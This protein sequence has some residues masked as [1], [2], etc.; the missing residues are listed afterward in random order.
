M[1]QFQPF[2]YTPRYVQGSNPAKFFQQQLANVE[3]QIAKNTAE[4]IDQ[5]IGNQVLS[6]HI[7][8]S[9]YAA[10]ILQDP[11]TKDITV[12][13]GRRQ[14]RAYLGTPT[15]GSAQSLWMRWENPSAGNED[16]PGR[17]SAQVEVKV[18]LYQYDTEART[19]NYLMATYKWKWPD[20][21]YEK[22]PISAALIP[23]MPLFA[24]ATAS[25]VSSWF[26]EKI[27]LL[28][29]DLAS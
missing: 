14:S 21:S 11:F 1:P 15:G 24:T 10:T 3:Q 12:T 4:I 26:T 25:Q 6:G 19:R 2:L 8:L 5:R 7:D 18:D 28:S 29:V 16:I 13:Y 22:V 9:L 23:G 17:S 20:L 27:L